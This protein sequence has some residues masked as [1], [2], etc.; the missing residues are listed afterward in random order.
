MHFCYNFNDL[1]IEYK[2]VREYKNTSHLNV[3]DSKIE[4]KI[5]E[6]HE[7]TL[8]LNFTDLK[9]KH[10]SKKHENTCT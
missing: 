8:H 5:V 3:I 10:K 2:S 1:K 9:V 7:N 4:G 6:N